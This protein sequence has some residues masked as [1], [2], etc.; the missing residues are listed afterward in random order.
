MQPVYLFCQAGPAGRQPEYDDCST[1]QFDHRK[2]VLSPLVLTGTGTPCDPI[3]T[4]CH[5]HIGD[6]I[7]DVSDIVTHLSTRDSSSTH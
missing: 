7:I 5:P 6:H 3:V 4:N 1:A 2:N